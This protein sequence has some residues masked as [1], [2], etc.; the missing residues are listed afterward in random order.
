MRYDTGNKSKQL[1][2]NSYQIMKS[3][4]FLIFI[5]IFIFSQ[6]SDAYQAGQSQQQKNLES[7]ELIWDTIRKSHWDESMVGEKWS[8]ARQ[9]LLPKIKSAQSI[10]EARAVMSELIASLGQSHFGVIPADSYEAM[11]GVKGGGEDIG[12]T[13]RLIDDQLIVTDVREESNAESAGIRPGWR[14]LKIRGKEADELIQ[15]FREAEHGP[16]RA[17]TITGLTMR[18]MLSGSRGAKLELQPSGSPEQRENS[19]N[20][21]RTDS[22]KTL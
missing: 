9:E 15:R 2:E 1:Q 3:L 19:R 21:L 20:R 7:F 5:A 17:E 8:Q 4:H 14:L 13:V 11:E 18:R 22:W 16:Q 12:L 10:E 6:S